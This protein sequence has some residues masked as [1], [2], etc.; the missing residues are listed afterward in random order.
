M[1]KNLLVLFILLGISV[2]LCAIG[3]MR[4]QTI[5]WLEQ[6]RIPKEL[7]LVIISVLPGL[8]RGAIPVAMFVFKFSWLKAMV[9]SVLGNMLPVPFILTLIN[10]LVAFLQ[11]YSHGQKFTEWL[12][13]HTKKKSKLIERY[14]AVGLMFLVAIPSPVTGVWTG[15]IAAN[16]FGISFWKS[17]LYIFIG[18]IAANTIITFLCQM[19]VVALR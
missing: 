1:R 5:T 12:F 17:L 10:G 15:S 13:T 8:E 2:S 7:I 3:G 19:G 4:E 14:K 6:N 11:R 18:A 9:L 16:I